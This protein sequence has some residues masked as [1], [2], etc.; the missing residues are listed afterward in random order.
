MLG[1]V[2]GAPGEIS[3]YEAS[4]RKI[5]GMQQQLLQRGLLEQQSSWVLGEFTFCL[6]IALPLCCGA[7]I[8]RQGIRTVKA[9][10]QPTAA[11]S[12]RHRSGAKTCTEHSS[13]S[14][15]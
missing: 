1:L 15:Q 3:A 12:L 11:P 9:G 4:G 6:P 5:L 2:G 10:E 14:P 7:K 8:A 13:H